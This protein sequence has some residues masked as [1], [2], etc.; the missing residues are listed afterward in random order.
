MST[1]SSVLRASGSA[2]RARG[3]VL[4]RQ[5][6]QSIATPLFGR[7]TVPWEADWRRFWA[8]DGIWI[9]EIG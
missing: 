7:V 9:A 8:L 2:F 3:P 5:L 6:G 4:R 1:R